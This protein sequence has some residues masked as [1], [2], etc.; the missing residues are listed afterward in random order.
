MNFNCIAVDDDQENLELLSEYLSSLENYTLLKSFTD[1]IKAMN[2]IRDNDDLDVVFMDIEMPKMSGLELS[3]IIRHRTRHLILTTAHAKYAVDAF[4]V[5]ADAYLLKPFSLSR[6]ASV[7]SK[8]QS[9][10]IM[11][12]RED[13]M[14]EEEFFF[15]KS[16]NDKSKLVKIRFEE[17]IAIESVQNYISIYT[18]NKNIV[19]HITLTK[20][21]EIL[22]PKNYFIQ[23][24]RS[25][26]ISK[27]Y[28][29]EIEN[30][31]IKMANDLRIAIG[32]NY[33][34][35]LSGFVKQK[36]IRTGRN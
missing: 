18:L 29:E 12:L 32:E 33:R 21:K 26:I 4:D 30:N 28:L 10:K 5:E 9:R 17:I 8:L 6:F 35:D 11:T 24:H 22:K 31:I 13:N 27:N 1:P 25:F 16:K 19:A 23:I 14:T 34:D 36:T 7:L 2:Y 15:I 20:I 3:R